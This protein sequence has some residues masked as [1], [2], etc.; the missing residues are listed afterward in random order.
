MVKRSL[1]GGFTSFR[2]L[3]N[4]YIVLFFWDFDCG[5]CK[6]EIDKLKEVVSHKNYDVGV[7]AINVNGDLEK[8]KKSVAE[9]E[10]T[11][12]NVNGT[13]SVTADFHD[14]YD[15]YGTPVIYLLDRNRNI[16]A[17]RIGGEQVMPFLENHEMQSFR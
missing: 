1:V 2:V 3:A 4:E 17:K 8:W 9:K 7:Y 11:W 12:L 5:I 16:V 15:I 10:L 13:R 14:L 6:K